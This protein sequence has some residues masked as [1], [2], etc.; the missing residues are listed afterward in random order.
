MIMHVSDKS[1][2]F[3]ISAYLINSLAENGYLILSGKTKV[4]TYNKDRLLDD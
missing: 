3:I 1:Y 2:I 4:H